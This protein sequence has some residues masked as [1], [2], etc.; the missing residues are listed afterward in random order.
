MKAWIL[1]LA[2]HGGGPITMQPWGQ[3]PS[4]RKCLDTAREVQASKAAS[5]YMAA[6]MCQEAKR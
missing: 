1:I 4:L 3:Y 2:Y 5:G 6:T